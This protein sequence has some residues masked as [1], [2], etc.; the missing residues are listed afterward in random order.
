MGESHLTRG[1]P[2][3]PR[4]TIHPGKNKSVQARVF[5]QSKSLFINQGN[6]RSALCL[7]VYSL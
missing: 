6:I 2:F 5:L 4:R 7:T 3:L 1:N